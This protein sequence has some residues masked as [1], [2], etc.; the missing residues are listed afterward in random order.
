M[1][2]W[3]NDGDD[4]QPGSSSS[5]PRSRLFDQYRRSFCSV[6]SGCVPGLAY[7]EGLDYLEVEES[8]LA[9]SASTQSQRQFYQEAGIKTAIFMGCRGGEIELGLPTTTNINVQMGIRNMFSEEFLQ[10]SPLGEI[11]LADQSRPSSSSSSLRS[12]SVGSPEYS[13]LIL[14]KARTSSCVPAVDT[15]TEVS[16]DQQP[17][18]AMPATTLP[19]HQVTMHAYGQTRSIQFPTPAADDAAIASAMLAVISASSPSSSVHTSASHSL[20]RQVMEGSRRGR[21][22]RSYNQALAPSVEPRHF[23]H[24]QR[25]IKMAH[26]MLRQLSTMSV[27]PRVPTSNQL[28]HMIAERKR[29]EKLNESFAA[30]RML[31]PQGTKKDKASILTKAKEYL[32][33]LKAQISDLEEKNRLMETRLPPADQAAEE[34]A[35]SGEMVRVQVVRV[36]A[37]SSETVRIELRVTVWAECDTL[38]LVL[39]ILECLKEMGNTSVASLEA[40]GQS[41]QMNPVRRATLALL[42]EGGEWDEGAFKEAVARAVHGALAAQ[43][44]PAAAP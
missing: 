12:V 32:N 31:L 1:D 27:Y 44:A 42:I 21:A 6:E 2:G 4:K 22:F 30:L 14:T 16:I 23:S 20:E 28:H 35:K 10:Q 24:G 26:A 37:S 29:R 43:T 33:S 9:T 11:F 41:S 25:M 38:D 3:F 8:R 5:T 40:N 7:K 39:P 15:T 17:T 13:S 19:P 36:P 18:Q 34:A